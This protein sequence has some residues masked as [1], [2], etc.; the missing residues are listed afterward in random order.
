MC[1][2]DIF[3]ATFAV[4]ALTTKTKKKTRKIILFF[5]IRVA[6]IFF[7]IFIFLCLSYSFCKVFMSWMVTS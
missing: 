2:N 5:N 6:R 4:N 3:F 7:F 1:Q